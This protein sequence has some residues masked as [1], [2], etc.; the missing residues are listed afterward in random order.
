M[1]C[2][3]SEHLSS[4]RP[5]IIDE[6]Y[7]SPETTA[8]HEGGYEGALVP[9]ADSPTD[10]LSMSAYGK[11]QPSQLH[12]YDT[13]RSYPENT[14][15]YS[16][17]SYGSQSSIPTSTP[18]PVYQNAAQMTPLGYASSNTRTAYDEQA[19]PYLNVGSTPIPEV[20]SFS[21][22]RGSQG[23]LVSVYITTLYELMTSN[24]PTFYLV[25]GQQKC[26]A[27]VRKM[28]QSGGVCNYIVACEVPQFSSA[29]WSSS[30]VSVSMFMEGDGDVI[31]KIDVGDFTYENGPQSM[32]GT[33][34][35]KISTESA[36]LRSPA[37]RN[38]QQ[39]K[40]KEEFPYAFSSSDGSPSSYSPYLQASSSY[41]SM[42]P[43]YGRSS[44]AYP[45]QAAPRNMGYG[46]ASS[47]T[48]SPPTLK[49]HSPHPSTWNS[50]YATI[51][52]SMSRSPGLPSHSLPRSNMSSLPSPGNPVLMRTSTLHSSGPG[53]APTYNPY[54]VYA[55]KAKLD[56]SGDLSDMMVSH[57]TAEE[58]ESKRRLVQFKR[59]QSGCTITTTFNPISADERPPNGVVI[60]CIYW[61]EKNDCY[62]T[63]VDTITLL[64]ALVAAKFTVE[65]KN[66]IRR[67]LEGFR[68]ATVSKGK[69]DSEEFFKVIMAFPNP[70]PRNIE[71]DVKVFHWKD[72]G[73][74]LKKIISKYSAS[75]SSTL[76][77]AH[78]PAL[79]TPVSSTG[80]ATE[81]SSAGLPYANDHHGGISPRSISGSTT[82]TA[83]NSNLP[84]QRAI[85]PQS[86]KSI[87]FQGG[88]PPDLRIAVPHGTQESSHWAQ[89]NAHH[90]PTPQQQYQAQLGNAAAVAASARGSWDLAN[91]LD[92]SP[93]TAAGTSGPGVDY[94]GQGQPP[95]QTSRNVVDASMAGGGSGNRALSSLQHQQQSQQIPRT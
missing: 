45:A 53:A 40:P 62:V 39:L 19:G 27:S 68:P 59:S 76:P 14:F 69:P 93:A 61:E 22:Q 5:I 29:N 46:Y 75:P 20:T 31:S 17:P 50:G 49:A 54:P 64:E 33:R 4:G 86:Q 11:P 16:T 80:Y 48:A 30:R 95:H 35:R 42:M 18:A 41:G 71:K 37:K 82:S 77:P 23:T 58:W 25:F 21:P 81:T 2:F 24:P 78:A 55:N 9:R 65:E 1:R 3:Q 13:G 43:Q 15:P 94:Q 57:W 8:L 6:T 10:I 74:A 67:N 84:V 92:S 56:I 44:G 12:G 90:M 87:S 34:K 47:S 70:K 73:P 79:L 83:Y 66:R 72:L 32:E 51:G 28:N 85:S 7:P 38:S 89:G 36:E 91:Y 88:G 26:Q 63:S 60:S 52:S